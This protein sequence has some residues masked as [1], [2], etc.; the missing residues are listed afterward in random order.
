MNAI[1]MM[2]L[3]QADSTITGHAR[4]IEKVH[5]SELKLI[6]MTL[7]ID[8]FIY[9]GVFAFLCFNFWRVM[10][11]QRKIT[12]IPLTIFYLSATAT[13]LARLIDSSGYLTY[14]TRDQNLP[15]EAYIMA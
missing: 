8:C 12:L 4:I 6:K 3:S 9:I 1:A 10:I 13:V 5:G 7:Y 11:R 14:Y 15:S 2:S